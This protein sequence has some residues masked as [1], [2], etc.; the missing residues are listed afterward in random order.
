MR[1]ATPEAYKLFHEGTIALAECEAN[2]LR[3][4][5]DYLL[6]QEDRLS[7]KIANMEAT[8]RGDSLFR[9]MRKRFGVKTN[10][11]SR[12]Q[13]AFIIYDVLETPCTQRTKTGQPSVDDA[14]LQQV[15]HPFI[16]G[17]AKLEKLRKI[18]ST[19][20]RGILRETLDGYLHPIFG[21]N[22]TRTYRSSSEKPNF[23][24]IPIRDPKMGKLV[25]SA[26][27]ARDGHCLI[28]TDFSGIEVC[29]AAC[30]HKD[31]VMIR[32]IEDPTKDMHRDMA[33]Q[34][35]MIKPEQVSKQAR[36]CA[37]NMFVF[38]E[39]YGD[40]YKSCASSLWAAI[41]KMSLE[42]EGTSL[43]DHLQECGIKRLG[44]C[45][46]KGR[47]VA[48][49]F[50][51]HLQKVEDDFW[52]RRF[53]VYG[54]WKRKAWKQYLETGGFSMLSGFYCS[55]VYNRKEVINYRVQ[56][57]AFHCLLWSLIQLSKEIRRRGMKAKLVGQ[58]HDSILAD[59]PENEV[60][61][62][63]QLAKEIM[64]ERLVAHWKWIIVPLK[65]EAEVTPVGGS[66]YE[67]KAMEIA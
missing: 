56:G 52:N 64:T 43:K 55:G 60:E 30:Y 26:F 34:C 62:Y 67:K 37:K 61:D 19:Y 21:L 66:W 41:D 9:T 10:L 63:L 12:D 35:Y 38:P 47:P 7:M 6:R 23:Q 53:R 50:E 18:R 32:Y 28:E 2:G 40:W 8:L 65:I 33:A 49:T 17:F 11:G 27:I 5:T 3:I 20:V 22:T 48:G 14:V 4:N 45:D 16:Q 25:R 36:Y 31:P 54:A 24:N 1:T 57:A 44:K 29:I 42:V 39:F 13:L 46:P 59:V 58:I 15:D 51:A